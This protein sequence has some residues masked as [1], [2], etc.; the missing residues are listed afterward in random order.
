MSRPSLISLGDIPTVTQLYRLGQLSASSA[1][2]VTLPPPGPSAT[3]T[4]PAPAPASDPANAQLNDTISLLQADITT[5]AVGAIVNAANS[6]LSGGG[7]VDGAIHAAAGPGLLRD[8]RA[9]GRCAPGS[10]KITNAYG[11]LPCQKVIHAVGP[12]YALAEGGPAGAARL[13]R[14][15]YRRS[16][17]LAV[18][19]GLSSVAFSSISTGV[20]GYPAAEAARIALAE[21]RRFLEQDLAPEQRQGLRRVVFCTFSQRDTDVYRRW[22]PTVFPPVVVAADD[23]ENDQKPVNGNDNA[24]GRD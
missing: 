20:Y 1:R 19:H 12:V 16:L 17:E 22:I 15:C 8:C 3:A 5:M 13:L 6:A 2:A 24:L 23:D 14:G 9:L 4:A 21:V 18:E 11:R 7:G 10:A